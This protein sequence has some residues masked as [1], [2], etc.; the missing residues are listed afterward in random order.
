MGLEDR[1]YLRDEARRYGAG[2]GG[3]G[4]GMRP[5][6]SDNWAIRTIIIMNVVVWV[7]QLATANPNDPRAGGITEWLSLSLN[8]LASFQIWR[9]LTYGFCHATGDLMHIA[10]NMLF[11]WMFGRMVEG[12]YG[13]REFMAFYLMGILIS[14]FANLLFSGVM[15]QPYVSMIGASGGVNAVVILTAMH[16]P[17]LTVYFMLF[18]PMPLWVL[19]IFY[20]GMDALGLI[21]GGDGIAHAAHLGGAAFGFLYFRRGWRLSPLLSSFENWQNPIASMQRKRRD[22]KRQKELQVFEPQ[23]DE[24]RAEVD[25]ILAKI[26]ERGEASLTDDERKTLERASRIFRGR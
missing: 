12:I 16:F 17:R 22:R 2:G 6:M 4:S 19:A 23:D 9:L 5:S 25:R 14:G 3:F 15:G 1:E 7:L 18:L 8:D 13:S 24:L 11:L 20:V 26:N 10:F 21:G